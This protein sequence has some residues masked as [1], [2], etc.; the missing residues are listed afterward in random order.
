MLPARLRM[1]AFNV[2]G[3]RASLKKGLAS[4]LKR[5]S[6]ADVVALSEVKCE[7]KDV[8]AELAEL[9]SSTY[10]H[11]S[12]NASR[13]TKGQ[14]GVAVLSKHAPMSVY[15]GLRS[16]PVVA[17]TSGSESSTP[18]SSATGALDGE[19]RTLTLE[20]E[21]FYFVTS[22][23]PNAGSELKRL[24]YR[25][26]TW[27]VAFEKHLQLLDAHKPVVLCGDLNVA[28]LETDIHDPKNN[29]NKSP[30]FTDAEREGF[31]R[32][33]SLGFVDAHRAV[34]RAEKDEA[35]ATEGTPATAPAFRERPELAE[36]FEAS[37][38]EGPGRAAWTYFGHRFNL[39]E[40]DKGWRLDYFVVSKRLAPRL[41]S[42]ERLVE[43]RREKLS[44]HC[45]LACELQLHVSTESAKE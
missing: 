36:P 20:F 9:R 45:G 17:A 42:V 6:F 7:E 35:T 28:H 5:P 32:L 33:L 14:S 29:R 16:T 22:Y 2:A 12:W 26:K 27:D 37:D 18:T 10:P 3:M 15:R 13:D 8:A 41:A 23:V 34:W 25:T 44:D 21:S 31:T 4:F 43:L 19:G 11:I 30:G 38:Q 40:K 24:D 1:V 39:F